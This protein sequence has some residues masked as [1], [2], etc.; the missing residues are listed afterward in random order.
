MSLKQG[1][2]NDL[3]CQKP[4]RGKVISADV[5]CYVTVITMYSVLVCVKTVVNISSDLAC[6]TPKILNI[7]LL[8]TFIIIIIIFFQSKL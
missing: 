4:K 1:T 8:Y 5:W 7:I 3:W 2:G 6:Q